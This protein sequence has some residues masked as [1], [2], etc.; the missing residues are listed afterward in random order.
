MA[1]AIHSRMDIELNYTIYGIVRIKDQRLMYVGETWQPL[2]RRMIQ[3][4]NTAKRVRKASAWYRWLRTNTD[5]L[6]IVII[7]T[8][9]GNETV[10]R[11]HESEVIEFLTSRGVK[12]LNHGPSVKRR[13]PGRITSRLALGLTLRKWIPTELREERKRNASK[14]RWAALRRRQ[15]RNQR[16]SYNQAILLGIK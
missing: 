1:I 5:Q 8:G 3:H 6:E 12:L 16:T 9:K 15:S 10:S 4:L 13:P 2:Q 7:A 14:L 11:I